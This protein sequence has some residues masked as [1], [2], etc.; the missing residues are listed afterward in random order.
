[1]SPGQ[2]DSVLSHRGIGRSDDSDIWE[3]AAL[4]NAYNKAVTSFKPALNNGDISEGSDKPKGI[5]KGKP[6]KKNKSQKKNTT[7]PLKQWK[8]GDKCSAI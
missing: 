6:T 1:M 8:I 4:I 2:E 5:P 7:I 3:D